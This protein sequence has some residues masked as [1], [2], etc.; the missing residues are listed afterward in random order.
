MAEDFPSNFSRDAFFI[1]VRLQAKMEKRKSFSLYLS[2]WRK[3]RKLLVCCYFLYMRC[4]WHIF[5]VHS[6]LKCDCC[7]VAASSLCRKFSR[8]LSY[9]H[10]SY[11][12][13][14]TYGERCLKSSQSKRKYHR[15]FYYPS[16]L[17]TPQGWGYS[18]RI[19]HFLFSFSLTFTY[20]ICVCLQSED[21][22]L[23]Y[24]SMYFIWPTYYFLSDSFTFSHCWLIDGYNP[25]KCCCVLIKDI[26]QHI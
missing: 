13:V 8:L 26:S 19:F 15:H 7:S 1:P 3:A 9:F 24:M 4:A 10:L 25:E 20:E 18:H 16:R 14:S 12:K 17:S 23:F 11:I 6:Y 22:Q 2:L 21:V 5:R